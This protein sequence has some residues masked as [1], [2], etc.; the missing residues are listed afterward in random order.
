MTIEEILAALQAIIDEAGAE[1][2]SDDAAARYEELEVQLRAAQRNDQIRVR[3][4][5]Y[6]AV[7]PSAVHVSAPAVDDTQDRAFRSYLATGQA[8]ADLM[9]RAQGEGTPS[10]GGYLVPDTMRD[11]IVERLKAFGGLLSEV[12]QYPTAS[13]NPVA[14]PTIDDTA[15]D[16]E[17][18]AEHQ[19][20]AGGADVV[21]GQTALGAHKY[22]AGGA[23]NLPIRLSW[24]LIADAAFPIENKLADIIA[25]RIHRKMAKDAINGTGTGA[26]TGIVHGTTPT[27]PAANTGWTY[28]DLLTF[29]HAV[30]PD[31]RANAKWAFNDTT[32]Q[33]IEGLKDSNGDPLWRPITG[34]IGDSPSTG[35]LLGY[36]VVIDQGFVNLAVA[37]STA[38]A[39]VF[40]DLKAAY[41]WRQVRDITLVVDPFSR[42][43]YGENEYVSWARADGTIQD[44]FAYVTLSGK[45]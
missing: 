29:M 14:W 38:H 5:A 32:L 2:M 1:P 25:K 9:V 19:T 36:P 4:A 40:G 27:Q 37:D 34:T 20:F 30:D 26:P 8:N 43:S 35:K 10:E 11:K 22:M 24:E 42:K 41:V 17:I 28:A 45:S 44:P 23:G 6:A 39:G 15:N 16:A 13:G 21:F 3:H 12:E 33:A 31:Y 18:V 7:P